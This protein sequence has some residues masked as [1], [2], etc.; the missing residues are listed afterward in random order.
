MYVV[1]IYKT[2]QYT[3]AT[4]GSVCPESRACHFSFG[5][6]FTSNLTRVHMWAYI[7]SFALDN[8]TCRL[9]SH[10]TLAP[11]PAHPTPAPPLLSYCHFLCPSRI[12]FHFNK[13]SSILDSGMTDIYQESRK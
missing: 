13:G 6:V 1:P 8:L 11:P 7:C 10:P 2:M 4:N 5:R 3:Q 12:H 9:E